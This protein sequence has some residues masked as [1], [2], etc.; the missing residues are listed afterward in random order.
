[1]IIEMRSVE[2]CPA[3]GVMSSRVKGRPLRR[4]KDLRSQRPVELWWRKRAVDCGDP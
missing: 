4:I 2:A 1:M 3:C